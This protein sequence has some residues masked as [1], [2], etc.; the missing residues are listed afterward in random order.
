M[1]LLCIGV[2][3]GAIAIFCFNPVGFVLCILQLKWPGAYHG[4]MMFL[5]SAQ[6][7]KVDW[8]T[9]TWVCVE[10]TKL[11]GCC[12]ARCRLFALLGYKWQGWL[13]YILE[14]NLA[15]RILSVLTFIM[16]GTGLVV[17]KREMYAVHTKAM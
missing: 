15:G 12:I 3:P 11:T 10:L 13:I 2:C 5:G 4:N 17:Y 6:T 16:S 8:L 1:T 7:S 14:F 9:E